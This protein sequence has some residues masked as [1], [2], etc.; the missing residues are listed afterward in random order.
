[1]YQHPHLLR[2]HPHPWYKLPL[3]LPLRLLLRLLLHLWLLHRPCP[4]L[5]HSLRLRQHLPPVEHRSVTAK[6]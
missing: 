1:M 2:Q 3:R 4:P 5:P 6:V